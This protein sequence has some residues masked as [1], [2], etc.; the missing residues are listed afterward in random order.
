MKQTKNQ[1][2]P[3]SN[4]TNSVKHFIVALTVIVV[5]TSMAYTAFITVVGVGGKTNFYLALPSMATIVGILIVALYQAAK[6]FK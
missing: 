1:D 2:A 6:S 4:K 3:K 5:L